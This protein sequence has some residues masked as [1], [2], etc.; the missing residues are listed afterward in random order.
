MIRRW[1]GLP[2]ALVVLSL[3]TIVQFAGAGIVTSMLMFN[4]GD[5]SRQEILTLSGGVFS[6]DWR[7]RKRVYRAD[8][9]V[10]S[11]S[12]AARV[13]KEALWL[14]GYPG[15]GASWEPDAAR[16]GLRWRH[17]SER[18]FV[19]NPEFSSSSVQGQRW[20]YLPD[21]NVLALYAEDGRIAGKLGPDGY[22]TGP[23][24]V[25]GFA[26]RVIPPTG[27]PGGRQGFIVADSVALYHLTLDPP[28]VTDSLPAPSDANN[29]CQFHRGYYD[30]D[31]L[32]V[33]GPWGFTRHGWMTDSYLFVQT[34]RRGLSLARIRLPD[35]LFYADRMHRH[36]EVHIAEDSTGE[37]LV[38]T[39]AFTLNDSSVKRFLF[40][41]RVT[42]RVL[43]DTNA[44]PAAKV[45]VST[46]DTT[47]FALSTA[48][49]G[50][51]PMPLPV[52]ASVSSFY[53]FFGDKPEAQSD[54]AA[55]VL[56]TFMT[57]LPIDWRFMFA[58]TCLVLMHLFGSAAGFGITAL[59]GASPNVKWFW[60][61]VGL[62]VGAPVLLL[63]LFRG[64]GRA[65][66]AMHRIR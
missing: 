53:V 6:H 17:A 46:R 24:P 54:R 30:E 56:N 64:P 31:N 58:A 41:D 39:V 33:S 65:A 3:Y 55:R 29:S 1:G 50:L 63:L 40:T 38:D 14:S 48:L 28:A 4:R 62:F 34:G 19:L 57:A 8:G 11:D 12:D 9:T 23:G 5:I 36:F 2:G 13:R 18:W 47:V 15:G 59:L 25:R 66:T 37:G 21:E 52:I 10:L 49:F 51:S 16:L 44:I 61:L 60:A 45:G 22:H 35:E 20:F 27:T 26:G 43:I 7:E 32:S 42:G